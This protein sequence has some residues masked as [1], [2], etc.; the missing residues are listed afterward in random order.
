MKDPLKEWNLF[1]QN[2]GSINRKI[3][4]MLILGRL[5]SREPPSQRTLHLPSPVMPASAVP[6]PVVPERAVLAPVVHAPVVPEPVLPAHGEPDV[7]APVLSVSVEPKKRKLSLE[8]Y[9][10]SGGNASTKGTQTSWSGN[11]SLVL[12]ALPETKEELQELSNI[13]DQVDR[14]R[15][16]AKR[17]LENLGDLQRERV[18]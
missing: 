4:D 8:E 6:T 7:F 9:Y 11:P 10:G 12:P 15:Y 5:S 13:M 14:T 17:K 1:S 18:R 16:L 2:A 3:G